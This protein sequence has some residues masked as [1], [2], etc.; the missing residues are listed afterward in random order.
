MPRVL[1]IM[2]ID[3]NASD[4]VSPGRF[5]GR[6]RE[7]FE[8]WDEMEYTHVRTIQQIHCGKV[9]LY[10][11]NSSGVDFA[12]KVMTKIRSRPNTGEET[13]ERA[14][15][16]KH[17][18]PLNEV[19][20]LAYL[21]DLGVTDVAPQPCHFYTDF[22]HDYIA[23]KYCAGGDL[24]DRVEGMGSPLPE[25]MM[26]DYMRQ[27]FSLV[28]RLHEAN[29]AHRD[30]SLENIVVDEDG[31][32]RLVD[33]SQ[34][35][36]I[37]TSTDVDANEIRY[38]SLAAKPACRAPEVSFP[39]S[40]RVPFKIM[41]PP[42]ARAADL[43][44]ASQQGILVD[45]C[46]PDDAVPDRFCQA[47]ARGY[48]ASPVDVFACGACFFAMAFLQPLATQPQRRPGGT[49]N[50]ESL[51]KHLR[52]CN[53]EIRVAGTG[54]PQEALD[55]LDAMLNPDP[56]KRITASGALQHPWFAGGAAA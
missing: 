52:R 51:S 12:V 21:A 29:I 7:A 49:A 46:L 45:V 55:L 11:Q 10:K 9:V 40:G 31:L 22:S 43:V 47:R 53:V 16:F 6:A 4:L 24:F 42:G 54:L 32:L 50:F 25:A 18:D 23:V 33:F 26:R 13:D 3:C 14:K 27:L 8:A 41:C 38:F 1:Q 39:D 30:I 5:Y 36:P 44:M 2:G 20:V 28:V 35:V 15:R 17:E 34:A 37:R 19:G 56:R 48:L